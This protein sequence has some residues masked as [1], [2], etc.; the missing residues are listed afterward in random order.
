[1]KLSRKGA[2]ELIGHEAIVLTRYKDSVGV[3]TIGV[4]HTKASGAPDPETYKGEMSL[5]EAMILFERDVARYV[6]DVNSVIKVPVTQTQ[7]DALVSFHYNTGAI[8]RAELVRYINAGEIQAAVNSFMKWT[9]PPEIIDRRKK[10]R[11]LFALGRYSN[12][13]MATIFEATPDGHVLWKKARRVDLTKLSDKI[14]AAEPTKPIIGP[15]AGAVVTGGAGAVIVQQSVQHGVSVGNI[16]MV[17]IL[18]TVIAA[19]VFLVVRKW[20]NK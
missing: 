19:A 12:G 4:G 15:V 8:R 20:G 1:M 6:A 3:W 11:D 17:S 14:P 2:M 9:N 10:E 18:V 13:G 16:V 5:D 7:F